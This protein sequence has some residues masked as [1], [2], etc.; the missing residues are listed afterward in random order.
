MKK[1][2]TFLV[3]FCNLLSLSIT[4]QTIEQWSRFEASF[5]YE[6]SGNPFTEVA[7]S[8]TFIHKD[9]TLTVKGFYDGNHTYKLRFM[10]ILPG[11]WYFKTSSN[12]KALRGKS[13]SFKCT[14]ATT[15]TDGPVEVADT[16]HFKYKNGGHYFPFGTTL[17]AWSH[18][19]DS[20]RKITLKNLKKAGF[21]KVRMCVLPKRYGTAGILPEHYPFKLKNTHTD[22]AGK[23]VYNWDYSHFNPVFFQQLEERIL[24]LD[25]LGIQA[26]LILFHPYDEGIWGFDQMP[27]AVDKQYLEYTLARIASFKNV[28]WSLANEWAYLD[29]KSIQDWD[30][31]IKTTKDNDPYN[32]LISI[33][34]PTA[35]YYDYTMPELTHVSIQDEAPV[36]NSVGTATLRRVYKKPIVLDEVGYE[37]NLPSRWGQLSGEALTHR[38]WNGVIA[39]G[40]VTHGEVIDSG[41][42]DNIVW[43]NGG[44]LKGESWK[45]VK[46]LKELITD[47]LGPLHMADISRDI[48]T[49]TNGKGDYL[50]YFGDKERGEWAFSLPKKNGELDK[51]KEGI[52]YEATIIDASNGTQTLVSER[53]ITASAG[54]YRMKDVADKKITLP[55]KPYLAI[56]LRPIK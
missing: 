45:A 13:G 42:P 43:A 12:I 15:I 33:H 27:V 35:V 2:V 3:I 47:D 53:F 40:Y 51:L 54:R 14:V 48:E 11:D 1:Y 56:R 25:A 31:L 22:K 9:T 39:G 5:S 36:L 20:L 6:H 41:D 16:F 24:E 29:T 23:T 8:G 55:N 17:Y 28:W 19:T 49:G 44:E 50:I 30:A 26:D 7:L 52:E 46:F 21:N 32:H 38:I 10:P 34:G 4:A 18:M 37:G